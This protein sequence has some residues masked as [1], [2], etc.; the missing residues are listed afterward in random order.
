MFIKNIEDAQKFVENFKD[1]AE[2]QQCILPT[3]TYEYRDVSL[4]SGVGGSIKIELENGNFSL[5]CMGANG[6]SD[7]QPQKIGKDDLIKYLYEHQKAFNKNIKRTQ[8][9]INS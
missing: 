3:Y 5:F 9:L 7:I 8:I 4:F 2:E 1:Y 6:W